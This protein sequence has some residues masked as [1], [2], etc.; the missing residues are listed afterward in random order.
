MRIEVD[1]VEQLRFDDG[2]PVRA[3]SAV[4][5]LGDGL[6]VAQDDTTYAAWV[7]GRTVSRLRLFP[8]VEGLD[9]F[10]ERAGTKHLKPD[11]EAACPVTVDGAPGVLLL[12]SGSSPARMRW[13][14]VQPSGDTAE[15]T[16]A[17]MAPL[18]V[19]VAE[20]LAVDAEVLNMEGACVVGGRLRWFHRG[21]PSAGLLS[22]SVDLVLDEALAAVRGD[23]APASV[24]VA[25][26]RSYDLGAVDGVG[27][28]VTDAIALRDGT[29]LLSAA[30]EDTPN[31]RD[32][33]P[34]V[35]SAL[36]RVDGHDVLEVAALP[37]V[38]GQVAKVEGLALLDA[39]RD[40]LG[41]LAVVDVDDPDAP[42]LALH[43][44]VRL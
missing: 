8:S 39:D 22:G 17:G 38:A 14:L 18:Y 44:S 13:A 34:V 10:E 5:R 37:T 20:A 23:L 16:A 12:G 26:P 29:L 31:P 35:G 28:A 41:L 15:V 1:R 4:A 32:D 6:L 27:L 30:A 40:D 33:G 21:L 43:L 11:L 42:S 3:A 9:T 2:S 36:V 7:R 24:A 25:D 19:A